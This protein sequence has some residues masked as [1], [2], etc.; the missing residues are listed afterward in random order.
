VQI[1]VLIPARDEATSIADTVAAAS[2]IPGVTRVIVIDDGSQDDT[3]QLA[4]KAGAKVLR[5]L[6]SHGKGAALEFGA[7]RVEDADIVLLLDG[8]LGASAAQ[9]ALLIAPLLAGAADMTIA[10]FPR[11]AGKAGFGLV[12]WLAR[13]GI[14]RLGGDFEATAPLSGQRALTLSCLATVRPF[15]AGYGVEVGLTVRAL[16]A[17]FRIAE[18]E[19]TMSHA[20]T[21]RNVKGFVHRGRQFVHVALALLALWRQAPPVRRDNS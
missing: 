6:G 9:G 15:S 14:A 8:D 7:K 2:A 10:T 12:K 19:T 18:V 17:G 1:A 13:G 3:D 21:G 4:E 16:R 5:L 20:A 11:P